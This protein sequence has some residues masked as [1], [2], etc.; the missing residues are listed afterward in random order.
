MKLLL[1]F[2][3]KPVGHTAHWI[4]LGSDYERIR[5]AW[6]SEAIEE[7][8]LAKELGIYVINFHSSSKGMFFGERR[9][10]ILDNWIKSLHEIISHTKMFGIQIMLEN[11]P[12]SSRIHKID[13]FKYIIDN[14]QGL[15]V[16]LDI[17]HAF[18]LGGMQAITDYIRTFREKIVH[19]HWHDNHGE[20]DEHLP[21]GE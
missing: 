10:I 7:A 20:Y 9:K 14:V 16:H 2:D 13:E 12:N 3:D 18:T 1:K 21:I 4:D 17:P 5:H 8:N 6:I 11:V 15:N 19:I